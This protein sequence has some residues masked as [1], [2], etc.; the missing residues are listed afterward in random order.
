[1]ANPW[2]RQPKESEPAYRAFTAYRDMGE[3]RTHDAI[4]HAL[5]ISRALVSRWSSKW[6]WVTRCTS[7]DNHVQSSKDRVALEYAEKW[8]RRRQEMLEANW[9][10]ARLL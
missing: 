6:S 10:D 3:S 7:W 1:M 8:E 5:G 2:D 4:V 9:A